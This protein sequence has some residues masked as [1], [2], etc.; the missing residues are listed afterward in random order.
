MDTNTISFDNTSCL[1]SKYT[2][3]QTHTLYLISYCWINDHNNKLIC[4]HCLAF[5]SSK[6]GGEVYKKTIIYLI[7]QA[8]NMQ[9]DTCT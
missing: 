4:I 6:E 2:H 8:M 5:D 7:R 3:I 9:H 1:S